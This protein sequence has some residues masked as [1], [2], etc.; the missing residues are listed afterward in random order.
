MKVLEK[1]LEE[2]DRLEDPYF[3]GYI[4]RYKV[5]EIIKNHLPDVEKMDDD[6]IPVEERLPETDNYILL[7]FDN[8]TLADIGRY[9]VDDDGSGAFYPG[10]EDTSY[11]SV[12]IFVNA[13]RPLPEPYKPK[14]DISA[15]KEHIMNRFMKVE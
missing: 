13:W 1:I 9:E 15:G 5:K 12:G 7:S 2:I 14:K 6:W 8:F 10:D 3:V 4:D 11:S